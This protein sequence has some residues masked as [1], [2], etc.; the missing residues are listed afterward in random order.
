MKTFIVF[1]GV[2]AVLFF[3][4]PS[5]A[6]GQKTAYKT[7]DGTI[8]DYSCGDNCY[9]TITDNK[10]KEHVG[11]CS[12]PVC[13]RWNADTAMPDS[14]RGKRVTV[15]VGKG[16]LFTGDG[17]AAGTMDAFIKIRILPPRTN[18]STQAGGENWFV[19]LGSFPKSQLKNA[20]QRLKYVQNLGYQASIIDTDDYAGLRDGFYSIVLGPYSKADAQ[21][22]LSSIRSRIRDAYVKSGG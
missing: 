18:V 19:I 2:V 11:L 12:S 5:K 22:S 6:V 4:V 14:Y 20:N 1:A 9:L 15:T 13:T 8:S 10:G 16:R 7:I 17:R 21:R 3:G